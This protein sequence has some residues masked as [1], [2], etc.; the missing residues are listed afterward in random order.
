MSTPNKRQPIENAKDI[1]EA[2]GGIRPMATKTGVAVT[3]VQ[4]WKKRDVIPGTR[5]DVLLRAAVEHGVDL[6]KFLDDAPDV[7]VRESETAGAD[8]V[9]SVDKTIDKVVDMN[10]PKSLNVEAQQRV[11]D[12]CPI[13][14]SSYTELA[15]ESEKRAITKSVAVAAG[16]VLAVVLLMVVILRPQY[17]KIEEREARLSSLE[18]ELYEIE[19]DLLETQKEQSNFKGFVSEDW[20]KQLEDLKRQTQ[21]AGSYAAEKAKETASYVR[22]ETQI[23]QRVERLQTYVSEVAGSNSIY[24]ALMPRFEAMRSSD[25]GTKSL[26]SSVNA[27]L[28]I[29][30]QTEGKD[31]SYINNALDAARSKNAALQESLG[32][33]PKTELKAAAMLLAMTQVRS[34]LN[35][36]DESFDSDLSLLMNMVDKDNVELRGSLEKIAPFSRNGVLS[37][38]GLR[39]EFQSVAGEVVTAS[40]RGEDVSLTEKLS[41]KFNDILQV[42]KDGELLTGTETQATVKEAKTM[43]D[44]GQ[45]QEALDY[46]KTNLK[47]KELA[48]LRPWM[49]QVE[50]ALNARAVQRA[51]EQ[52]IELNFGDGLLGGSELLGKE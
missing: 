15:V 26:D 4:G 25:E 48:P 42:E 22:D 38:G 19:N 47:A 16:L 1:I 49:E 36:P 29:F 3:T 30:E 5:R 40:L 31:D 8:E 6:S 44:T 43:L 50:A 20:S 13:P 23:G 45:W 7:T 24:A 14:P 34:A 41:A 32:N 52:A 51:I 27:L 35:R 33:V 39:Q 11:T 28:P 2:F 46:L 21:L 18:K 9:S 12:S 17:E 10:I 37:A